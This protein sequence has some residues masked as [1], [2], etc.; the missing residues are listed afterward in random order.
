M[1]TPL[2]WFVIFVLCV[3]GAVLWFARGVISILSKQA[4]YHAATY[5]GAYA[6]GSALVA[7]AVF[8]S[9]DET[10]KALSTDVAAVLPWWGWL[11][12]FLKPIVA[13]LAVYVAFVDGTMKKIR[14]ERE[15][16]N[17]SKRDYP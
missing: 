9:Y 5:S 16:N 12:L 1:N 11:A 3:G 17:E 14:D 4:A 13:G 7:I 8:T 2:A 10:F 6:K 15:A